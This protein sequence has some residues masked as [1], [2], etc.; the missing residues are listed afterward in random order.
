MIWLLFHFLASTPPGAGAPVVLGVQESHF[1]VD[2]ARETFRFPE[3]RNNGYQQKVVPSAAGHQVIV[4]VKN[5]Q[6]ASK[7]LGRKVSLPPHLAS[8]EA[9]LN[10]EAGSRLADQVSVLVAW[11]RQEIEE[12][13][14][15]LPDQSPLAVMTRKSANCV[16]LAELMRFVLGEMGVETRYV[17]G[18]AFKPGDRPNLHLEGDVLHRWIEIRY[19]DVGWVFC[20]PA[21]KVNFVASTYLV[22]GVQNLH[23]LASLMEQ[24]VD[25]QIHWLRFSNGF[26]TVGKFSSLDHRIR[27]RP[28]RLVTTS[29]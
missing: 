3:Y 23:P 25:S 22:L 4:R 7:M 21:G 11:L 20:D 14:Q 9:R 15:P 19:E 6:L 2:T 28:N 26:R 13:D 17:T 1:R 16:G 18:I 27:I 29:Y 24:A 10:Q 12:E 5:T 8:L